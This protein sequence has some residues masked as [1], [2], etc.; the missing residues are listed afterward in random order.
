MCLLKKFE[1]T[2]VD[3][4]TTLKFRHAMYKTGIRIIFYSCWDYLHASCKD[5]IG[6]D[7]C[8]IRAVSKIERCVN[9]P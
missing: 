8:F 4:I 2:T 3:I 7:T 9:G 1:L 6:T 5:K